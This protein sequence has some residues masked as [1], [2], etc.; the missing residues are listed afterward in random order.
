[1]FE[2]CESTIKALAGTFGTSVAPDPAAA[3]H[4][5]DPLFRFVVFQTLVTLKAESVT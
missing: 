2:F 1:M 4:V 3:V 5:G